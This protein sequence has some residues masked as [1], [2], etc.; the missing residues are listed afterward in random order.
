MPSAFHNN[1][2]YLLCAV[3]I[4]ISSCCQGRGRMKGFFLCIPPAWEGGAVCVYYSVVDR[5]RR[6]GVFDGFGNFR[7]CV[8][9]HPQMPCFAI[10]LPFFFCQPITVFVGG[11]NMVFSVFVSFSVALSGNIIIHLSIMQCVCVP[12]PST[13]PSPPREFLPSFREQD[14]SFQ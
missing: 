14:I 5:M 4:F 13:Y 12:S 7:I 10:N 8:Q 3:I 6:E 2:Y 9:F 1:G 11:F